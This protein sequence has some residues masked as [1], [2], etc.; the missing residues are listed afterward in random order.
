MCKAFDESLKPTSPKLGVSFIIV[1]YICC[2]TIS[3]YLMLRLQISDEKLS[4]I[5]FRICHLCR[6]ILDGSIYHMTPKK[7][8]QK[9]SQR[10]SILLD[11]VN[12]QKKS[13]KI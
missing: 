4:V 7:L 5:F 8:K 13:I 10:F 12:G 9:V 11:I 1:L 6:S 3:F 2:V